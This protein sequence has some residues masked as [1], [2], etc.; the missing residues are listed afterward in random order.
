MHTEVLRKYDITYEKKKKNLLFLFPIFFKHNHINRLKGYR[1]RENSL[2]LFL[3]R[4]KLKYFSCQNLIIILLKISNMVTGYYSNRKNIKNN[5]IFSKEKQKIKLIICVIFSDRE[6][7]VLSSLERT[8]FW[9][10]SSVLS[11]HCFQKRRT[12]SVFAAAERN[13]KDLDKCWIC[14]RI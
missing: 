9:G 12:K 1:L 10:K 8:T 5:V 7:G 14:L 13:K 3:S 6:I 4:A 11:E 2:V